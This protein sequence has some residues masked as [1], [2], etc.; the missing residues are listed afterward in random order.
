MCYNAQGIS[1][2]SFRSSV[3]RVIIFLFIKLIIYI[4]NTFKMSLHD[5]VKRNNIDRLLSIL[6]E[7]PDIINV[8]DAKGDTALNVS[9]LCRNEIAFQI[10]L[11]HG[12]LLD[13]NNPSLRT[14]IL[15]APRS[16]RLTMFV[17]MLADRGAKEMGL[18]TALNVGDLATI[19][20][21]L[22]RSCLGHHP[23]SVKHGRVNI[24]VCKLII[25]LGI[26][27]NVA[28]CKK[29]LPY[30]A[31]RDC[32][33]ELLKFLVEHGADLE[34]TY[35]GEPNIIEAAEMGNIE[36]LKYLISN[37]IDV[38]TESIYDN[39]RAIHRAI[40]K[41]HYEMAKILL[42]AGTPVKELLWL[43]TETTINR[44][45]LVNLVI[46][47][48]AK[49]EG[50]HNSNFKSFL[51][52]RLYETALFFPSIVP[53]RLRRRKKYLSTQG[54]FR[55]RDKET[56]I[57]IKILLRMGLCVTNEDCMAIYV[58]NYTNIYLLEKL[59]RHIKNPNYGFLLYFTA[60]YNCKL[61]ISKYLIGLGA[62]VNHV[63][64]VGETP[65]TNA[66]HWKAYKNVNLLLEHGARLDLVN[67]RGELLLKK[68]I[69]NTCY[70]VRIARMIFPY[71]LRQQ[72]KE[73]KNEVIQK[74]VKLFQDI[75]QFK[76]LVQETYKELEKIKNYRVVNLSMSDFLLGERMNK[77]VLAIRN[78]EV[79]ERC[80][81][82]SLF[83]RMLKNKILE[84]EHRRHLIEVR[85]RV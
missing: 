64:R 53:S 22:K 33:I 56:Y 5:A 11:A 17:R 71:L 83:R 67:K 60:G 32:D 85:R 15:S 35:Q 57:I 3:L 6:N 34:L 73:P 13:S 55:I 69:V 10:L 41:G 79:R 47:Y 24:K 43:T 16:N 52:D 20:Y 68:A 59:L 25:E 70:N 9:I 66:M 37:G 40:V 27:I 72:L 50:D 30:F 28:I 36:I 4:I 46:E 31:I 74:C 82:L 62:D 58:T 54:K 26:D 29:P 84:I 51:L 63:N 65:L 48:G 19:K 76:S 80:S 49:I 18:E 23:G 12:C 77:L 45:K 21:L 39:T 2:S 44:L 8:L 61:H 81:C 14:A 7:F 1:N 42:E 75:K 78:P 38:N